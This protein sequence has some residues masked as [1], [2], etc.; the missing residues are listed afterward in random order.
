MGFSDRIV[1]LAVKTCCWIVSAKLLLKIQPR[2][3]QNLTN[4]GAVFLFAALP[5]GDSGNYCSR[6]ACE[7]NRECGQL[8]DQVATCRIRVSAFYEKQRP[9]LIATVPY[10]VG[11]RQAIRPSYYGLAIML[12][13][14]AVG[15]RRLH[16]TDRSG[17]W[18][19]LVFIPCI[20]AVVLI[21]FLAQE[22]TSGQNR[23][24][25]RP[26]SSL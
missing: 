11:S 12:P 10:V 26:P 19:L 4:W 2:S 9:H 16:D 20:G 22:G 6:P 21:V 23:Y 5:R 7:S 1:R 3:C 8:D 25:A 14:V 18:L 17:W 24:G 15:V 13:S